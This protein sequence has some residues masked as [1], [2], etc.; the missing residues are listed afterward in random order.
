M[1]V[2]P[3]CVVESLVDMKSVPGKYVKKPVVSLGGL[4]GMRAD[5]DI[6]VRV[7]YQVSDHFADG[8]A[9]LRAEPLCAVDKAT[10]LCAPR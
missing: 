10:R 5:A 3:S 8:V 1:F 6:E 2:K 4:Q 7:L 9:I